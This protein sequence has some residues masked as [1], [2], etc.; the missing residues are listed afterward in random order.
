MTKRELK[1]NIVYVY[2]F[3]LL[4]ECFLH[5]PKISA[6]TFN[7]FQWSLEAYQTCKKLK[8]VCLKYLLD[9]EYGGFRVKTSQ[10]K[11]TLS[12]CQ[13]NAYSN[14]VC[15]AVCVYG[16]LMKNLFTVHPPLH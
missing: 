8:N 11:C 2:N 7:M 3:L 12:L 1:A 13:E 15:K 9:L 10:Q 5:L 16:L 6:R 14:D 4:E